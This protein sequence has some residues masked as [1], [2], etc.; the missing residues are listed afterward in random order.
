MKREIDYTT[1]LIYFYRFV[2]NDP[3]IINT[4]VGSTIDLTDRKTSHK[5]RCNNPNSDFYHLLVYTTIRENGGWTN[6]RMLEI[7]HKIVK[8]KTE[9]K[10]RE[11]YWIEFYNAQMNMIKSIAFNRPEYYRQYNEQHHEK[12]IAYKHEYY[13]QHREELNAKSREYNEQHREER[14]EY[15]REYYNQNRDKLIAKSR[16]YHEQNKDELNATKRKLREQNDAKDREYREKNREKINA[17]SR[18]YREKHREEINAKHRE[19]RKRIKEQ[20]LMSLEDINI[21]TL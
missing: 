14:T 11:Q 15:Q 4:Y 16:N 2:C 3:N 7:E 12:I 18:E 5:T 17:N 8:D 13:E 1:R 21:N 6:W 19:Q 10:Q 9:A 20:N